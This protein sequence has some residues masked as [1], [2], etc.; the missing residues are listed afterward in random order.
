MKE[1]AWKDGLEATRTKIDHCTVISFSV[2]VAFLPPFSLP[3]EDFGAGVKT[4]A[5]SLFILF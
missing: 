2:I 5:M 4:T 3:A 1:P